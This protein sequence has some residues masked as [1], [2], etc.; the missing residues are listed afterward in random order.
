MERYQEIYWGSLYVHPDS[1]PLFFILALFLDNIYCNI[2]KMSV[3]FYVNL[4]ILK[5]LAEIKTD[6]QIKKH[7]I[8]K[9]KKSMII[10]MYLCTVLIKSQKNIPIFTTLINEIHSIT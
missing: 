6:C 4:H 2:E 1:A 7:L 10:V 8:G 3:K 5:T 9:M